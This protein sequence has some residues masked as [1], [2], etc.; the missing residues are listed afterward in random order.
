MGRRGGSSIG[1]SSTDGA[2][3]PRPTAVRML[4]FRA[5][6]IPGLV[7]RLEGV[8]LR[9]EAGSGLVRPGVGAPF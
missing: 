8:A 9:V 4:G 3:L 7:H 6:S 2:H 1:G 5:S